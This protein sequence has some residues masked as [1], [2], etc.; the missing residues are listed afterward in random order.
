MEILIKILIYILRTLLVYWAAI[1]ISNSD[2]EGK[3]PGTIHS[4]RMLIKWTEPSF[5]Y[6]RDDGKRNNM[7]I[8]GIVYHILFAIPSFLLFPIFIIICFIDIHLADK[9]YDFWFSLS[10]LMAFLF[11]SL[12]FVFQV[13]LSI[14]RIVK[15]RI[16]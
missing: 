3:I 10:G 6:Y 13:T 16:R 12:D 4:P 14:A 2:R 8:T 5:L 1:F 9:L 11:L 7:R 15:S